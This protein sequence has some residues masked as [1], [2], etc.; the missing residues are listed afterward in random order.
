MVLINFAGSTALGSEEELPSDLFRGLV[1]LADLD[2]S[3][4][5]FKNLPNMDDLK[6]PCRWVAVPPPWPF[7]FL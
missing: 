4:C 7:R 2:M 5:R 3:L 6:V 1:N